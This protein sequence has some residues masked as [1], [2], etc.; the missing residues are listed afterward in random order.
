M[1]S[2]LG[3]MVAQGMLRNISYI[4]SVAANFTDLGT[5]ALLERTIIITLLA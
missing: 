1:L 3:G 2:G 5:Y 4:M